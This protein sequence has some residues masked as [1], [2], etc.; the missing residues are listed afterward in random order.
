MYKIICNS[1]IP[2]SPLSHISELKIPVL[3]KISI[4]FTLAEITENAG[5]FDYMHEANMR[6]IEPSKSSQWIQKLLSIES[7]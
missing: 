5:I 2:Y 7:P 6:I 3:L 4:I 1:V